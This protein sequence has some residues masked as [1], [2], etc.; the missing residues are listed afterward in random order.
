MTAT[1]MGLVPHETLWRCHGLA[2]SAG[3][4]SLSHVIADY[5]AAPAQAVLPNDLLEGLVAVAEGRI[6]HVFNGACPDSV[7][8]GAI[9][10]AECPA[11][12]I[13]LRVTSAGV[14]LDQSVVAPPS[15]NAGQVPFVALEKPSAAA[16]SQTHPVPTE[17]ELK[18]LIGHSK[19]LSNIID[20]CFA[21]GYKGD[22][23][24]LDFVKEKLNPVTLIP[25]NLTAE[26]D[27]VLQ[28]VEYGQKTGYLQTNVSFQL[29]QVY[30]SSGEFK[31][32]ESGV[33]S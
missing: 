8:G 27:A 25:D 19:V 33:R 26:H 24:I 31:S 32:A 29:L 2:K 3:L 7:E 14:R 22:T 15:D 1:K 12:Q 23:S 30:L 20:A 21:R 16:V 9:R 13:L 28:V 6:S 17:D 10:D 4:I 11:C 5:I 18:K